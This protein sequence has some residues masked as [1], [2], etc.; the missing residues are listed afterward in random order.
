MLQSKEKKKQDHLYAAQKK[1][2]EVFLCKTKQTLKRKTVIRDKEA[3]LTVIKGSNQ[4]EDM[5]LVNMHPIQGHIKQIVTVT[6]GDIDRNT[7]IVGECNTARTLMVRSS[8]QNH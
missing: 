8:R 7:I 1:A 6:K 3:Y 4:Q 2:G 5:T